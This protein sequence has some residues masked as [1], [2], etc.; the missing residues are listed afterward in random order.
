MPATG[1]TEEASAMTNATATEAPRKQARRDGPGGACARRRLAR[2]QSTRGMIRSARDGRILSAMMLPFFLVRPPAGYGLLTTTGRKTGK[3]RRKCVRVIRRGD[4][5]YLTMLRPPKLALERP[6]AASAWVWNIRADPRVE[7]RLPGATFNGLARELRSPTSWSRRA[8]RCARPSPG[9]TTASA[10]CTCAGCR[11]A[12]RSNS[13]TATG[14]TPGSRWWS[15][16][17]LEAQRGSAGHA[18]WLR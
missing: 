10:T 1:T 9:S 15:S 5:A 16:W 7:L 8:R 13:C 6:T 18:R 11:R 12:R 2:L 17:M 4:R 3:R 14:S